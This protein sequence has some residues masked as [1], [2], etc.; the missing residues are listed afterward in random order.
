M[1]KLHIKVKPASFKDEITCDKDGNIVIKI[2]EK[3]INGAAND[4]LV[5]YIA[6]QFKLNKSS[7]HLAKGSTNQHK[8]ILLNIT[9]SDLEAI[10]QLLKSK[11]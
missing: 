11:T 7:V 1:L 5:K 4:Y 3:P 9:E 2:R 10:K 8:T 6:E